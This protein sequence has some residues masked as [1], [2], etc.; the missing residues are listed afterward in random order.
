MGNTRCVPTTNE[1]V[2]TADTLY[3][4]I[5]QLVPKIVKECITI[6]NLNS[7]SYFPKKVK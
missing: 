6:D 2:S 7:S 5:S 1:S 3:D 4:F